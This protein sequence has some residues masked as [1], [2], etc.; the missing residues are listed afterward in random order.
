[1]PLPNKN[2]S[3]VFIS[4]SELD[5]PEAIAIASYLRSEGIQVWKEEPT[6][7]TAVM[8]GGQIVEAIGECST[9]LLLLSPSSM[10]SQS[11]LKQTILASEK[12][13]RIVPVELKSTRL[14]PSFEYPLAG[15]QRVA[16]TS[17]EDIGKIIKGIPTGAPIRHHTLAHG[18]GRFDPRKSLMVLPFEDLS[19]ERDNSWF[20]DGLVSELISVL[21][22]IKEL[23]LID[24]STSRDFKKFNL[25]SMDIARELNVRYFIE[26]NVRKFGDNI[27]V[28]IQLL[29]I[30]EGEYLWTD[31][32]K[33]HF[34]DIFDIQEEVARRVVEG[35]KVTLTGEEEKL[36]ELRG[37]ENIEAYA[38]KMK[39]D[40]YSILQTY[41]GYQL[42]LTLSLD[43]LKLDPNFSAVYYIA[44]NALTS[45]FRQYDRKPEHLD[46]AERIARQGLS[47]NDSDHKLLS[48]LSRVYLFRKD[49]AKAEE[50]AMEYVRLVPKSIH[51]HMSLAFVYYVTNEP[52]KAI[53]ALIEAIKLNP[54]ELTAHSNLA[55][56]FDRVADN[57]GAKRAAQ[58][59]I[60]RFERHLRLRPDDQYARV[61]LAHLYRFADDADKAIAT[62]EPLKNKLDLD[63]NNLY[64][65]GCMYAILGASEDA[66]E[67][68]E[69]AISS[70]FKE[71]EIFHTDPDLA[72]LRELS[73][74]QSLLSRVTESH[75]SEGSVT[76]A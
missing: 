15:I 41:E 8:E 36:I 62:L 59:G 76:R 60:P 27:K 40:E 12:Q 25:R 4:Y 17:A 51:S 46:E 48:I 33:G 13:K 7:S 67:M 22:R 52:Q 26:G 29:D 65:I 30:E 68:L 28:S 53:P 24:E 43:A 66:I 50:T 64:N 71:V 34:S 72:S 54:D 9:F 73:E 1:M 45:I 74:F 32:Y 11:V 70:G 14:N 47:L 20:G 6:N 23:R 21:S 37:T 10:E 39:A 57:A 5:A 31:S 18:G 35:L 56:A 44:S 2:L 49:Y 16:F 58:G 38:L 69:R 55:A 75:A 63:G 19:P 42:A 3:S 61:K